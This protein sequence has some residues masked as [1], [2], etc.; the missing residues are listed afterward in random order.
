MAGSIPLAKFLVEFNKTTGVPNA[1]GYLKFYDNKV[2]SSNREVFNGYQSNVSL[3]STVQ[4]DGDGLAPDIWLDES[5]YSIELLE[6]DLTQVWL[7]DNVGISISTDL[8]NISIHPNGSFE[9]DSNS[10]GIPDGFEL[11]QYAGSSCSLVTDQHQ[12]GKQSFKFYT[13]GNGGGYLQSSAFFEVS[14]LLPY[15]VLFELICDLATIRNKVE[16]L[17]YT[18]SE[19]AAS[20]SLATI[21]DNESSNPL[22]WTGKIGFATP[23]SDARLA[24][25]RIIGGDPANS[26]IGTV[27]YE[28][29]II[30]P[31]TAIGVI[32]E[33]GDMIYADTL[34][35]FGRIPKGQAG[36]QL[37]YGANG[38]EW[39]NRPA[40]GVGDKL[41]LYNHY[42]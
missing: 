32:E 38:P 21:Y 27:W 41:Y 10:D 30:R 13:A 36:Q 20:T 6:S 14:P 2:Y 22:I 18:E 19:V 3:G 15:E 35:S 40:V 26:N 34:R 31:K 7:K 11:I 23:P 8:N 29:F 5:V 24:K 16:F 4:L 12:H 17:W 42:R 25:L 37:D 1:Y 33:V 39:N 9:L 28:N